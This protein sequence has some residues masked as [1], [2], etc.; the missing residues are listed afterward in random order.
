MK[1]Y[2]NAVCRHIHQEATDLFNAGDITAERM[3]GFDQSCLV[4]GPGVSSP[5]AGGKSPV[6]VSAAS[7][8]PRGRGVK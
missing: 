6:T 3:R 5:A 2:R 4:S 8:D 1:K 7:P